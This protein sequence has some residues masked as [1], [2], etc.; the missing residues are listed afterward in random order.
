MAQLA[1]QS[2]LTQEELGSNLA[3]CK[4]LKSIFTVNC[5]E[6]TKI[7]EKRPVMSIF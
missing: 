5:I 4:L 2:L 6:K 7:Y 3:I 1:E